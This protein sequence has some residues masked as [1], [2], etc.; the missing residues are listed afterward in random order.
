MINSNEGRQENIKSCTYFVTNDQIFEFV[1]QYAEYVVS[2][3][4]TE[5]VNNSFASTN[6]QIKSLRPGI[7]GKVPR[8]VPL[9]L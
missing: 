8:I 3:N 9:G 2:A 7:I 5:H 6:E 4:F 1:A